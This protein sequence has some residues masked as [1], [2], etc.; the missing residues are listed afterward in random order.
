MFSKVINNTPNVQTKKNKDIIDSL[1]K[2]KNLNKY[3]NNVESFNEFVHPITSID[4]YHTHI[5]IPEKQQEIIVDQE[6]NSFGE[7]YFS[8]LTGKKKEK[9][10][11]TPKIEGVTNISDN[12]NL[13]KLD[14]MTTI[15]IGS[16]SI[17]ALYAVYRAIRKTI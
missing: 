17:I 3:N 13:T 16:L 1:E 4:N 12:N 14:T 7:K 6:E 5:S 10:T 9:K 15:Y 11:Q 2:F 8:M